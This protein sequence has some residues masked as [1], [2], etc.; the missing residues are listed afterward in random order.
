MVGPL[1][2]TADLLAAVEWREQCERIEPLKRMGV[3]R[4]MGLVCQKLA[5]GGGAIG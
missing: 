1:A 5:M 4:R 3:V 2:L